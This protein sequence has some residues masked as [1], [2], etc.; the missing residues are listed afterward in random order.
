MVIFHRGLFLGLLFLLPG[1]GNSGV[2]QPVQPVKAAPQAV[3][4]LDSSCDFCRI[5]QRTAPAQ[6]I[7]EDDDVIAIE[8][9]PIRSPVNCLIIPKK[10]IVNI[11]SLNAQDP[12]DKTI[13]SKMA[14]MAQKLSARLKGSGDFSLRINNGAQAAQT[15][16][17]MHAHFVSPE[18]WR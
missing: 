12:F 9:R 16:F 15:V 6:I 11:K 7:D 13:V 8:K 3:Q 1:C 18:D 5:I 2:A 10:H 4:P 14:F 17:H